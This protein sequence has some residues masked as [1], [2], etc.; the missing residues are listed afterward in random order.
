MLFPLPS[1]RNILLTISI[2]LMNLY[3]LVKA[4]LKYLWSCSDSLSQKELASLSSM[5]SFYLF[6]IYYNTQQLTM[7]SFL[8]NSDDKASCLLGLETRVSKIYRLAQNYK[9]KTE[10]QTI[11]WCCL[12]FSRYSLKYFP[13]EAPSTYV[14]LD[15]SLDV[16][17]SLETF[18]LSPCGDG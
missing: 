12:H 15:P 10:T 11:V 8:L 1:A 2:C 9:T 4:Q 5:T 13:K 14:C 3:S 16:S 7:I 17:G 18:L 6:I